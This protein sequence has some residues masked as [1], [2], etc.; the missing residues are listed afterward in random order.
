MTPFGEYVSGDVDTQVVQTTKANMGPRASYQHIAKITSRIEK[1]NLKTT[2]NIV[3]YEEKIPYN[4][5]QY[6]III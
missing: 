4:E 3:T 2:V 5:E 6:C 1:C